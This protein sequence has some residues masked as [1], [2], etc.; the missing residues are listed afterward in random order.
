MKFSK[1]LLGSAVLAAAAFGFMSCADDDDPNNMISGS[2]NNYSIEYTNSTTDVS[3]GYNSTNLQHAG[4]LVKINFASTSTTT[5]GVMGMIFDLHDGEAG[6]DFSVVGLRTTSSGAAYYISTFTDV[7]K[8]DDDNFGA[9]YI[10]SNGV[11]HN[12]GS[13]AQETVVVSAF[14]NIT[15]GRVDTSDGTTVYVYFVEVNNGT[16][17][18]PS[19]DYNVYFLPA[20][21]AA[22]VDD[23][24]EST[25][26]L[27]D[28]EDATIDISSYLV[29][30]VETGY[31]ELTQNKFAVYANVYASSTLSGTWELLQTYKAA[32]VV[33]D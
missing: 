23:V 14:T 18:A 21:V 19:Y 2:N 20:T 25:G 10:D 28:S 5:G 3:R 29:D 33:E 7:S 24:D 13:V 31:S 11:T 27:L 17:E 22:K 12:E 8:I 16:E 1:V 26:N 6:K 32:D 15:S 9:E 4:S 30:T